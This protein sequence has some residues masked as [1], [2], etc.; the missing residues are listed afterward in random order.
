MVMPFDRDGTAKENGSVIGA[1]TPREP[2]DSEEMMMQEQSE[3][4]DIVIHQ[5]DETHVFAS[6]HGFVSILQVDRFGESALVTFPPEYAEKVCAAIR[7]AAGFL[8]GDAGGA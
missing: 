2:S 1:G 3:G 7:A 6:A 4:Q 5:C 8:A